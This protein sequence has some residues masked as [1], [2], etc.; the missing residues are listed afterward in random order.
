MIEGILWFSFL[1]FFQTKQ[2]DRRIEKERKKERTWRRFS[3]PRRC[4]RRPTFCS[5]PLRNPIKAQR[6]HQSRPASITRTIAISARAR[7]LQ[8]GHNMTQIDIEPL[9]GRKNGLQVQRPTMADG[10]QSLWKEKD[11]KTRLPTSD[12]DRHEKYKKN[13]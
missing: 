3:A 1:L 7:T 8:K 5:R 10:I 2:V 6:K 9:I 13:R 12:N 11:S 4:P